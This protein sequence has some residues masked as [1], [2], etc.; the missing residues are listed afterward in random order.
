MNHFLATSLRAA[1][2]AVATVLL[3][4][5]GAAPATALSRDSSLPGNWLQ[6]T[7]T[8]GTSQSRE[9][10]ST[11]L[12]CD[13]PQGHSRAVEACADLARAGGDVGAVPGNPGAICAMLYAPV[14]ARAEGL[15]NGRSVRYTR[16]FANDCELAALT[17]AVFALDETEVEEVPEI[18]G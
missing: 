6:L 16:T 7:L 1:R 4:A 8:H 11:L 12:L 17:G 18:R 13:P 9:T 2:V 3:A 5:A 14:T 10:N 15:W